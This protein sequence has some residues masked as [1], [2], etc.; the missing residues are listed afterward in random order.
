MKITEIRA[1]GLTGGT[2]RGGWEQELEQDDVVHTLV[3]VHTDVGLIGIGSVFTTPALVE[4]SLE[5][6][7]PA[8]VGQDAREPERLSERLHR[9]TFWMGH[10][11][12]VT[13]TISGVDTALWDLLGKHLG[14]PVGRLLGG[15]HRDR[16]RPYASLLMDDP[17][18]MTEH[19]EALR[20]AGW[21]AFKIGWGPFGRVDR[22]VDETIVAAARDAIGPQALLMVDAGAS[23]S[24]WSNGLSWAVRTADMLSAYDVDWFEEPLP[25]DAMGDYAALRRRSAVPVAGG[26]ILTRRQSF[27][28]WIEAGALDVVQPDVT[29]AGGLSEVR[30]IGW[31]AQDHGIKLV[32]HGWNTAVGLAADLQLASA[33]PGTDLV[34]YVTGSPYIDDLCAQPWT[35]DEDGMLPIPDAPGLGLRLDP[36]RLGRYCDV[37]HLLGSVA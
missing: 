23:D 31:T 30:R 28:P 10:G 21:T 15:R 5:L 35:L 37:S 13:H 1:A 27:L 18:P 14:E 3:A 8:L 19:L 22:S 17:A 32:P 24:A 25:P 12:A 4:A 29:K 34:E 16:V 11:G 9:T 26:E 2:P 20:S 33:L 6:L 36:E 7:R